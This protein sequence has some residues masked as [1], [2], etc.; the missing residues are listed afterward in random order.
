MYY[1]KAENTKFYESNFEP[2]LGTFSI[3][4]FC[5]IVC[6]HISPPKFLHFEKRYKQLKTAMNL[7]HLCQIISKSD[8]EISG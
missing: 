1:F 8:K 7:G 4:L 5:L 2:L 6:L 3:G